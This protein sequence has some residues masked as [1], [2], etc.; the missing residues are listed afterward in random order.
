MQGG[1]L[2]LGKPAIYDPVTRKRGT[3]AVQQ[4][5]RCSMSGKDANLHLMALEPQPMSMFRPFLEKK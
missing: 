4:M 3:E 2:Q 1:A 5:A